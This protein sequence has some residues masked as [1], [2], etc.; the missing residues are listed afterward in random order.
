M[1]WDIELVKRELSG[2]SALVMVPF[3]D[4]L[5]LNPGA[6]AKNIRYMIDG[7]MRTGRGH[8]ICPCGT[9]EYLTLSAAEHR[10]VVETAVEAAAGEL[11]LVAGVAGININEVIEMAEAAHEAGAKYV[12]VSPPF[13][14]PIDQDGIFEWYRILNES[15]GAGIMI[16]DQS[17]RTDLGTTLSL[18]LIERLTRLEN[19]VSLKF[20]AP[21]ILKVTVEAM[22]EFAD[23]FAFIDNSLGYIS[24]LAHMHGASGFISGPS[25]WWP[26]FELEFFEMMERGEYAKADKWHARLG[27][28]MDLINGEFARSESFFHQAAIMKASLE[29]VGQYGGPV[30]PPF[31][32]MNTEEK[33]EV[34]A[35]LDDLGAP[36]G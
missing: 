6:L 15:V 3:N 25:V 10:Q 18:P 23:R 22:D 26:E 21:E 14:D 13:Y 17:W 1:A 16:Y 32:A 35:V 30:R 29:Y 8:M 11:P 4:D 5:S 33:Q 9:G 24:T 12:M 31:R 28:W 27:P 20:G 34:F 2:P 19:L 36:K 7:G